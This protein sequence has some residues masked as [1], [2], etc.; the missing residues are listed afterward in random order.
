MFIHTSE[1]IQAGLGKAP[2]ALDAI[3][4]GFTSNELI[5]C[6]GS[7]Q[8]FSHFCLAVFPI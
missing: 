5:L 3:D 7:I 2:E 6:V 8:N 1:S 4:M